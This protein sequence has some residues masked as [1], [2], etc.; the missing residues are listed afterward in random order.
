MY[1]KVTLNGKEIKDHVLKHDDIMAGGKL[2]F[3]MSAKPKM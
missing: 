1:R 2:V 3:Y